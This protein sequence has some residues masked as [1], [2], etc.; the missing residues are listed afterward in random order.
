MK[1][2]WQFQTVS[3]FAPHK[4]SDPLSVVADSWVYLHVPFALKLD[5]CVSHPLCVKVSQQLTGTG[6]WVYSF[7]VF[8]GGE[9]FLPDRFEQ[10]EPLALLKNIKVEELK[11]HPIIIVWLFAFSGVGIIFLYLLL[12]QVIFTIDL[13]HHLFRSCYSLQ[14]IGGNENCRSIPVAKFQ[15]CLLIFLLHHFLW[16][17]TVFAHIHFPIYQ[18]VDPHFFL[19][20]RFLDISWDDVES[21]F[22]HE[23]STSWVS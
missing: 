3:V 18:H 9:F 4:L 17:L 12:S 23:T 11:F 15:L 20:I 5:P 16:N 8:D 14:E 10:A 2:H 22:N 6:R 21:V 1:I 19:R 7:S 13:L